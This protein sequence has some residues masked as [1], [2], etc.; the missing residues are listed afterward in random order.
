MFVKGPLIKSVLHILYAL[1][2]RHCLLHT[3]TCSSIGPCSLASNR[4][5]STMP[6]T[7]V[8]PNLSKPRNILLNFAT[9]RTFYR[10]L[11]I[12]MRVNPGNIVFAKR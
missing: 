5:A 9:K 6:N 12:E 7:S 8:T 4:Q 1:L 3:F 11:F 10:Q 2:P